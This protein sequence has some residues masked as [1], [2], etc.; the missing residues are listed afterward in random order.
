MKKNWFLEKRPWEIAE[1]EITQGNT[2][3][4]VEIC[5]QEILDLETSDSSQNNGVNT[6]VTK[7]K[8]RLMPLFGDPKEQ[9]VLEKPTTI[10]ALLQYDSGLI[11]RLFADSASMG[12]TSSLDFEVIGKKN[13][14]IYRSSSGSLASIHTRTSSSD[15]T[16]R[17]IRTDYKISLI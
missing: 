2:G 16:G 4:V 11:V 1:S 15:N 12:S 3:K 17:I 14:L 7:W 9:V 10:S 8:S 5:I 6:F 13:T